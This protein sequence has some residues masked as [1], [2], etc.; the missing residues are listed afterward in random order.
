MKIIEGTA[1]N[2]ESRW[3]TGETKQAVFLELH[4]SFSRTSRTASMMR[5]RV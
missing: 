4:S 3:W 1:R 5:L 2:M